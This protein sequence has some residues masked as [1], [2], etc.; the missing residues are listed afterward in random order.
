MDELRRPERLI[1]LFL[2]GALLFSPVPLA[3][4]ARPA[5]LLGVPTLVVYV[6]GAW[7]VLVALLALLSRGAGREPPER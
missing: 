2:L 1:A 3:V 5:T 6:F 4:F 7:A